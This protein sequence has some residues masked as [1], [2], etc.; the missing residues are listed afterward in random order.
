MMDRIPRWFGQMVICLVLAGH[1]TRPAVAQSGRPIYLAYEGYF[2]NEDGTY[3][4]MF[5]YYTHN[6]D[7]VTLAIGP[8]NTF[9]PSTSGDRGQ[10]TIFLPAPAKAWTPRTRREGCASMPHRQSASPVVAG[11]VW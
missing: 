2:I 8:D 4:L 6:S 7:T 9:L 5:G 10:S 11:R 1:F 3:T